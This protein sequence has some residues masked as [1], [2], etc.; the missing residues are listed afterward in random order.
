MS[1]IEE[2]YYG[3][4]W[5]GRSINTRL[6]RLYLISDVLFNSQQPGVRNAFRYRDAIEEIAPQFFRSLGKEIMAL[7]CGREH[8]VNHDACFTHPEIAMAAQ[9]KSS[10][11]NVLKKRVGL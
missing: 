9:P 10:A 5:T 3:I 6:A 2:K 1:F 7:S 4:L 8:A 11:V